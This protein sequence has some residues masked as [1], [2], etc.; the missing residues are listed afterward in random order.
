MKS[1]GL[2][3]GYVVQLRTRETS[4]DEAENKGASGRRWGQNDDGGTLFRAFWA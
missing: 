1:W 4:A 2:V 3:E